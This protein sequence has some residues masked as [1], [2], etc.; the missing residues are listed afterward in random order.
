MYFEVW[1][2]ESH[3]S[4]FTVSS[5]PHYP[6]HH[7]HHQHQHQHQHQQQHTPQY[8]FI[9]IV[10]I[11]HTEKSPHHVASRGHPDSHVIT[12]SCNQT[13][14][15][16]AQ[17][18]CNPSYFDVRLLPHFLPIYDVRSITEAVPC[19][20]QQQQQQQQINQ[21]ILD[22]FMPQ[23]HVAL[24]FLVPFVLLPPSTFRPPLLMQKVCNIYS[25]R[26]LF[27]N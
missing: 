9:L 19:S 23:S 15:Y 4:S 14:F 1:T 18:Y 27:L 10:P 5:P 8:Q 26:A 22:F 11:L 12:L 20:K 13:W 2:Q 16:R 21:V 17:T 3:R 25:T 7:H 24:N 6:H